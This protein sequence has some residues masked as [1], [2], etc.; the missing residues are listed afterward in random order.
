VAYTP[1]WEPLADALERVIATGLGKEE[2]KVD[3]CG[4]VADGKIRI[5]VKVAARAGRGEVFANGNVGVPPRLK[6]ADLDW[7]ASRP[8]EPWP[9]GPKLGEHYSWISGW[10]NKRIDLIEVS[11]A[12][13][14]EVLCRG[15]SV[16]AR[17]TLQRPAGDVPSSD[18]AAARGTKKKAILEAAD[19]LWSGEIPKGLMSKQRDKMLQEQIRHNGGSAP[20]PRTI[21]RALRPRRK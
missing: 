9:I 17:P 13:L 12:D 3:L 18:A 21:Q 8:F 11:T 14:I 1:D 16:D 19:Q 20:H 2:V 15:S 4:A 6:P 7:V 10:E 5:R